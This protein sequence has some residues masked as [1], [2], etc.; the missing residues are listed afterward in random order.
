MGQDCKSDRAQSLLVRPANIAHNPQ[1]VLPTLKQALL[2][3]VLLLSINRAPVVVHPLRVF[4]KTDDPAQCALAVDQILFA[5][6]ADNGQDFPSPVF[7]LRD[8][9]AAEIAHFYRC[10]G[11]FALL[12]NNCLWHQ[13][14]R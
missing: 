11:C 4:G 1:S 8:I 2:A 13:L 9:T 12:Q 6:D 7:F 14:K 5:V 3:R 10:D